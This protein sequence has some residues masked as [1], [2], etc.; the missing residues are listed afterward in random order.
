[1]IANLLTFAMAAA[2]PE[3]MPFYLESGNACLVIVAFILISIVSSLISILNISHVD[4]MKVIGGAD[5]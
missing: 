3:T 4:P 1:M 2:L 5:E